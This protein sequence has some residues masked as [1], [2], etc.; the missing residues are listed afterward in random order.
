MPTPIFLK[1]F[2]WDSV[3]ELIFQFSKGTRKTF[4]FFVISVD[5]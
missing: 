1:E 4:Q 2:R 5:I 3:I